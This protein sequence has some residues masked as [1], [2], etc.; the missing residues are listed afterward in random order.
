MPQRTPPT[1]RIE[2][3][4][5]RVSSPPPLVVVEAVEIERREVPI[6]CD[7]CGEASVGVLSAWDVGDGRVRHSL[8]VT[9]CCPE[10]ERRIELTG[11]QGSS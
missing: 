8:T 5:A 11:A 9:T 3:S 6:T 7:H 4:E 10:V 2:V 1:N